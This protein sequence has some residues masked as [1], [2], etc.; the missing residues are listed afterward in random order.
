M[1]LL[2]FE[3]NEGIGEICQSDQTGTMFLFHSDITENLLTGV[4]ESTEAMTDGQKDGRWT[5]HLR[6]ALLSVRLTIYFV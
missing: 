2:S 3:G 4:K 1:C 5:L 6:L